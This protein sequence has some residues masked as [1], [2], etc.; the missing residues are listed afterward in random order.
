MP[1]IALTTSLVPTNF[2]LFNS[3]SSSPA[4]QQQQSFSDFGGLLSSS[5]APQSNINSTSANDPFGL[6]LL[7]PT[8]TGVPWSDVH[9]A[10]ICAF[11]G[12]APSK[13]RSYRKRL[14]CSALGGKWSIAYRTD[15]HSIIR[16]SG[17]GVNSKGAV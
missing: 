1:V 4:P 10:N 17:K 8:P 6:G 11:N 3:Q 5:P 9:L 2:D 13:I 14:S 16:D 7:K 12:A 15:H